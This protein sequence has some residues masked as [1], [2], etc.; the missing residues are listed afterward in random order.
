MGMTNRLKQG[1]SRAVLIAILIGAVTSAN[2]GRPLFVDD[3]NVDDAQTGH[4]E[5]WYSRDINNAN[6]YIVSPAYALSKSLELDALL[7]RDTTQRVNTVAIQLKGLFTQPQ[8]EGCNFG[9]TI[10]IARSQDSSVSANTPYLNGL[11][12]CNQGETAFHANAGANKPEG[13]KTLGTWGVALEHEWESEFSVHVEVFGQQQSKPT[14]QVGVK[15][16]WGNFQLDAT[17]GRNDGKNLY[18]LGVK[19]SFGGK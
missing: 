12:T 15:K 16:E 17:A 4:V 14:F 9:G 1:L 10:G 2:A 8:K 19:W 13:S 18:S 5:A 7:S 11:F 6:A 3:A